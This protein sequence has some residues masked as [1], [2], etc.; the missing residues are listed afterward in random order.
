M[1]NSKPLKI[2]RLQSRI[3]IGGPAIHVEMLARHLPPERFSNI[4]VGGAVEDHEKARYTEVEQ[5]NLRIFQLDDMKRQVNLWYDVKSLYKFYRFLRS[6]K[7]DIVCTHTAKAGA[8]G[9]LAAFLAG[10]PVVVHTF[11]GHVFANY[12]VSDPNVKTDTAGISTNQ[13]ISFASLTD[14]ELDSAGFSS[15]NPQSINKVL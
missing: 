3:C 12:F 9:R 1:M 10:V 15:T 14:A 8:I 5:R 13:L 4:L 11:H 2:V 6:E 7:P